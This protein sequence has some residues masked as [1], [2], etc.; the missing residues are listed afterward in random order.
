MSERHE[1]TPT[2]LCARTCGSALRASECHRKEVLQ[3]AMGAH[4]A[5]H[6]CGVQGVFIV[7]ECFQVCR[8]TRGCGRTPREDIGARF[9][10]VDGADMD[11]HAV[12]FRASFHRPLLVGQHAPG[13][14]AAPVH[15]RPRACVP[16]ENCAC[17][18]VLYRLYKPVNPGL[19]ILLQ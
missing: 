11:T 18:R 16:L 14:I 5:R 13:Q 1:N 12:A 6:R 4:L 9:K 3:G 7:P 17:P 10:G 15:L 2:A 8:P 19:A